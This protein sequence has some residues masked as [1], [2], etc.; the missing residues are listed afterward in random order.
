MTNE[1]NNSEYPTAKHSKIRVELLDLKAPFFHKGMECV[2]IQKNAK[3]V[4]C[5]AVKS[6][7]TFHLINETIITKL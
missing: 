4:Q 2:I 1:I 7:A 3:N 5:K 6:G